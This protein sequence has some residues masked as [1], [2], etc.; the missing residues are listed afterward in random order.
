MSYFKAFPY[1]NYQFSDDEIKIYKDISRRPSAVDDI[2]KYY[3]NLE[4]YTIDE[5]ETPE[6]LANRIYGDP[7]L[8]WT[9]LLVNNI[10]NVYTD[11]PLDE[12]VLL[13]SLREQYRYDSDMTDTEVDE[14]L[15]FVGTPD[16][17][18]TGT[19]AGYTIHPKCFEDADGNYYSFDSLDITL[20]ARG[21]PIETPELTPVSYWDYHFAE[22]EAKRDIYV[23]NE[24]VA[25][26]MKKE[27]K[28]LI[29]G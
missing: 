13:A 25:R 5:G 20:D 26:K 7:S 9:I 3:G 11:W 17:N 12:K 14:V 29:N 27:L 24:S 28:A 22:N 18:Y 21:R 16:N 8:H 15:T 23:P 19:V 4:S 2:T 6:L 10:M 1:I